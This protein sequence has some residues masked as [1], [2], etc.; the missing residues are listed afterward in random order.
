[1]H[2]K[3]N[4]MG[5]KIEKKIGRMESLSITQRNQYEILQCNVCSWA[6]ITHSILSSDSSLGH[7]ENMRLLLH[8]GK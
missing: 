4:L 2:H 8:N 7:G 1:M 3:I 6:A 5:Q